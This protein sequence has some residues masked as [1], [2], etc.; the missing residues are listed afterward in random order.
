MGFNSISGN[1]YGTVMKADNVSFDGTDRGG[2]VTTNG[3]LL[4]GSSVAPH[5]RVGTLTAGTGIA[6]VNGQGSITISSTAGGF[7]W[8]DQGVNFNADVSNG[9]FV[10]AALTATLPGSAMEGDTIKFIVDT[11]SSLTVQ[12]AGGQYIRL[13]NTISAVAG[14]AVSSAIGDTLELVF[15]SSSSTWIAQ[16]F[17]GAWTVT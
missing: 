17:N 4:I 8:S 6:I 14:T 7:V 1:Q 11:A 10:T 12:A 13:A 15:R 2:I 9:Y 5:I 3:Q 16:S